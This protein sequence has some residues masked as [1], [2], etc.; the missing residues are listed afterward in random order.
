MAAPSSFPCPSTSAR[1]PTTTAP[2]RPDKKATIYASLQEHRRARQDQIKAL[3]FNDPD[4][5]DLDPGARMR[6][7]STAKLIL[8][9]IDQALLRFNDGSH[10]FC[11]GWHRT[12]PCGTAPSGPVRASLRALRLTPAGSPGSPESGDPA[13]SCPTGRDAAAAVRFAATAQAGV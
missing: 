13:Q 9:E 1:P 3:T 8:S 10:G 7:L 4:T 6:A 11:V 12:D 2:V 5:S